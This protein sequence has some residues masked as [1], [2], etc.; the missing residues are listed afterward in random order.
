MDKRERNISLV[1]PS[2]RS[3]QTKDLVCVFEKIGYRC[4]IDTISSHNTPNNDGQYQQVLFISNSDYSSDLPAQFRSW[5]EQPL[6]AIFSED[7]PW[8][9]EILSFCSEVLTWPCSKSELRFRLERVFG[10]DE[11]QFD[12]LL[13]VEFM[14]LNMIGQAPS[15]LQ[16]LSMIRRMAKYDATILINGETGT[17]KELVARA[18]HYLGHSH[19]G[20]FIAVNCGGIPDELFENELFG[21]VTG[22]YTDAKRRQHG[23]VEQAEGG[24]LFLDEIDALSHK[25]QT[26]LLRFLQDQFYKPLGSEK[27]RRANIRLVA[28]T[29]TNL[30]MLVAS[31]QFRQDLMF[32]LDVMSVEL[33]AL[34]ERPGDAM[35]LANHF[36]KKYSCEYDK[37]IRLLHPQFQR[38]IQGHVWPGN[39]RE[40]EN[41]ILRSFLLSEGMYISHIDLHDTETGQSLSLGSFNEQKARAIDGFERQYLDRILIHTHGNVSLA[42]KLAGKER[43]ALGKLLQKHGINRLDYMQGEY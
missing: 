9:S 12:D 35:L 37:P 13:S 11:E 27:L 20:P 33:P 25:S 7:V 40:L 24:T 16:V 23:Y 22:A 43:R 18:L 15:F 39:I 34:R 4:Q 28:A 42:A 41:T 32:R 36:V 31:Q 2:I 38:W 29:N 3:S 26:T 14:R 17:G 1:T 5:P 21:H 8:D 30:R 6:L 10:T 19:D